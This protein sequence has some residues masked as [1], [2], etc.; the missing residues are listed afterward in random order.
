MPHLMPAHKGWEEVADYALTW[1]VKQAG[2]PS[3]TDA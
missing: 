1:A 3:V 2:W